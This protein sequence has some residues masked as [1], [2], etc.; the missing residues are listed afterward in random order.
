MSSSRSV[1]VTGGLGNLGTKLMLHLAR[2]SPCTR[3]VGLDVRAPS[4]EQLKAL[5]DAAA[6][7]TTGSAPAIELLECDLTD[8]HDRRWRDALQRVQAVV[9]FA[10]LNP[11]PD[12]S[13]DDAAVSIDMTLNVALAA[14]ESPAV[15]RFV[16]ATSNHVMGRYKDNPL[17]AT[18]GP[19]RLTPESPLGVGTVW[20]ETDPPLDATA[21]ST[22]KMVG[23]RICRVL[24]TH[25]SGSTTFVSARIGWCQPGA[26]RPETLDATGDPGIQ[27]GGAET[28]PDPEGYRRAENWFRLMWLSNRDFVHLFDRAIN[29][30]AGAWPAPAIVVNGMSDNTGM[31]WSLDEAR[32]YLGYQPSDD[33][34]A[35]GQ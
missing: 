16:F 20:A 10:A 22:T 23:E 14:A 32:R 1:A 31:A 26:N 7:N 28:H 12:A 6:Q 2:T 29:A 19:G 9:H 3:L 24:G 21:Y 15:E 11:Y 30:D 34:N 33:V 25:S 17:A 18:V 35:G 4:S 5:Q 8:L 27:I 13:W